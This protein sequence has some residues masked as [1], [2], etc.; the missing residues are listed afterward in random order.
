[1]SRRSI[2]TTVT[3]LPA[4]ITRESVI[5]TLYDHTEM[6]DLNPLVIERHPVKPPAKATPE[7]YHCLWYEITDRVQYLPGG[8]V[9]GKVSYNACFHNLP[10]GLQTH[11][12][13]P[14][15]LDIKNKWS[16]GGTLPGEPKEPMELG[17]G[18]P[19]NGLWLR[20]DV[21]MK[22]NV[23]MTSFVKRTLKK[24]HATLVARLVEKAHLLETSRHNSLLLE[25][26]TTFSQFSGHQ[27]ASIGPVTQSDGSV[28]PFQ[29]SRHSYQSTDSQPPHVSP[30]SD[31]DPAYQD[32]NPYKQS[33]RY[34]YQGTSPYDQS[35]RR[36]YQDASS[37]LQPPRH[38]YQ[39][40]SH[41]TQQLKPEYAA[42][43]LPSGSSSYT[44]LSA[45][46]RPPA[47]PPKERIE[48]VE[49]E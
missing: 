43:E 8:M 38:S 32:A 26:S 25:Q 35:T 16:L 40:A 2:F 11:V 21:E 18:V 47:L 10:Q 24:A 34:S 31:I 27:S 36:S 9:S 39:D 37:I 41:P 29:N 1:M 46:T 3:P 49:L 6:I 23:V 20:E 15:G 44:E 42:A 7:E 5:A 22:C 17:I 19:K 12:Y 28:S 45:N 33:A 48:A 14:L 4:G 13:A 30:Y